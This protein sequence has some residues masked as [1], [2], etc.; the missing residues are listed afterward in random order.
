MN[1]IKYIVFDFGGV[2]I[3]WNPRYFFKDIFKE[4]VELNFFLQEVCNHKWNEKQDEGR[5][6]KEGITELI[7]RYPEYSKEIHMYFTNWIDMVNGE[8]KANT[9][10]IDDLAGKYPM[11]GLTNWSVETLPLIYNRY[12]FFKKLNGIIVSGKEKLLKPNPEIYK[13]L[14]QKFEID[15][16]STL[17][18]DD[19]KDNIDTA[20]SLGFYTIWLQQGVNLREEMTKKG[21][22]IL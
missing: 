1:K 2:L 17:F 22:K 10:L 14:L 20:K 19:N 9:S 7:V 21:I 4:E 16:K 6:F 13:R 12:P 15:A 3:D 8:I 11:Y 5:S 18:I